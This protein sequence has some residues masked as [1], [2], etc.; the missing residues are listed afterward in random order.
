MT[1]NPSVLPSKRHVLRDLLRIP[2]YKPAT[3]NRPRHC[4]RGRFRPRGAS[5]RAGARRH[6]A[7]RG[8]QPRAH[9]IPL[10]CANPHPAL[11]R[12][13][14]CSKPSTEERLSIGWCHRCGG[15]TGHEHCC[16]TS[17]SP[18]ASSDGEREELQWPGK[19]SEPIA[20]ASATQNGNALA[21]DA[22][23]RM[24]PTA[25]RCNTLLIA[26]PAAQVLVVVTSATLALL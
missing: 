6:G 11:P 20:G 7:Q 9:R 21:A 5:S 15:R 17:S 2:T 18:F 19:C 26:L 16:C 23:L 24:G 25:L 4:N 1:L 13:S 3:V 14:A 8:T 22:R 12:P 10:T